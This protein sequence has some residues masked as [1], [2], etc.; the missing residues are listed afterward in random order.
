MDIDEIRRLVSQGRIELSRH[1]ANCSFC[2]GKVVEENVDTEF[3]WG[4]ELLIFEGVPAG[5][6][7]ECG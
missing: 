7:Q 6:C 4:D 2:K 5:V 1:Y 3:W